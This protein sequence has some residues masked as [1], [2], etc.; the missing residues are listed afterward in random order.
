MEKETVLRELYRARIAAAIDKI[1]DIV[2]LDF[3]YRLVINETN[4]K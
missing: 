2:L 1:T 3:I 4:N